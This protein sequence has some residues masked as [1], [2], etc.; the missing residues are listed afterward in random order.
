MGPVTCARIDRQIG[1]MRAHHFRYTKR[2]VDLVDGE[3]ESTSLVGACRAQDIEAACI[4]VVDL[5]AEAP[6][7]IHL[8]DARIER[9]EGNLPGAQD[10]GHDLAEA[11]EASDDH[12]P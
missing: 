11:P 10:T 4:T 12:V 2:A 8:L 3:H 6:H 7:E 9:G 1:K 5:G